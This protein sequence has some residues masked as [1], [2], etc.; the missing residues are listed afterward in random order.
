MGREGRGREGRGYHGGN[1]EILV[2]GILFDDVKVIG[3]GRVIHD[4]PE[5]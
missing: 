4:I 1:A 3:A 5:M 2:Q